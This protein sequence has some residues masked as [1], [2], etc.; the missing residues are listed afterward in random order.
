M[1]TAWGQPALWRG[2]FGALYPSSRDALGVYPDLPWIFLDKTTRALLG[3]GSQ[4]LAIVRVRSSRV[5]QLRQEL[6]EIM[7]ILVI[8]FLGL[9]D[10][11]TSPSARSVMIVSMVL[12]IASAVVLRMRSRLTHRVIRS[13]ELPPE[14]SRSDS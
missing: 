8:A 3:L 11:V 4:K 1:L 12:I 6:R 14:F 5:F 7:L 2:G 9:V 13:G 10:I